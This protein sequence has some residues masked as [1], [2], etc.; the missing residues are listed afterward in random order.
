MTVWEK[1]QRERPLPTPR[2][3]AF[4]GFRERTV[5]VTGTC[6]TN[7]DRNKYSVEARAVGRPVQLQVYATRIVLR[8]D[9]GIVGEH[10][11]CFGR[12]KTIFNPRHCVPVPKRKPGALRNGAPFRDWNLPPAMTRIWNHLGG[13]SDGACLS[14]KPEPLPQGSAAECFRRPASRQYTQEWHS[15]H[16]V[17]AE[18][19]LRQP[20]NRPELQPARQKQIRVSC[21]FLPPARDLGA[22]LFRRG[23]AVGST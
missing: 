14:V 17:A 2:Q 5:A 21:K 18:L 13:M 16:G 11:R 7:F 10:D 9:G 3:K 20:H 19:A 12:G 1:F 6:L 22:N 15:M 23:T 8:R 4:V